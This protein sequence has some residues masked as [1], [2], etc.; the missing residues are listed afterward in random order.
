LAT[1]SKPILIVGCGPGAPEYVTPAARDAARQADALLGAGRLLELFPE[2]TCEKTPWQGSTEAMLAELGR[3]MAQG[4]R[5]A[6]LV[7]GDPGLFSLAQSVVRRFGASACE[8]LPAIS[9]VQVA[10]A[11]VGLDWANARIISAHGRMPATALDELKQS[12]KV[13]ILAGTA[14]ALAWAAEAASAQEETHAAVVCENLT[15]PGERI[16]HLR[17]QDIATCGASPLAI[18]LLIRRTLI[19]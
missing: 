19:P 16:R 5:V 12:D 9:P 7:S 2:C 11:R 6:V 1:N 18:V 14:D 3:L 13:A 15:L 8:I 4:Q 10:F 17:P